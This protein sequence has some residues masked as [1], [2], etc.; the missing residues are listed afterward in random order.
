MK[1]SDFR[2]L[3]RESLPWARDI[4]RHGP[5]EILRKARSNDELV[6][7]RS[8]P[9]VSDG[10][11]PHLGSWRANAGPRVIG[12]A[13]LSTVKTRLQARTGRLFTD[14]DFPQ[15][16]R[17]VALGTHVAHRMQRVRFELRGARR[18]P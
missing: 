1:P 18:S 6:R 12:G 8:L 5:Q 10:W 13:P 16:F 7:I 11:T 4:D 17:A 9:Q 2:T 14:N 3:P 15:S